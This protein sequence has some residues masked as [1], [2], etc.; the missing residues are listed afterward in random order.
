[1]QDYYNLQSIMQ[2][3]ALASRYR[4][5]GK[6]DNFMAS[7]GRYVWDGEDFLFANWYEVLEALSDFVDIREDEDTLTCRI[8]FSDESIRRYFERANA[9]AKAAGVP[10]KQSVLYQN[11]YEYYANTML[12]ACPCSCWFRL[13]A[14]P[15]HEYGYGL[16]VWIRE[17]QFPDWEALLYGL[18]DVMGYF[19][20]SVQT[21]D[22]EQPR[23]KLIELNEY[24][25][26]G[27]EAA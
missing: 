6:L 24:R 2:Q 15:H 27:K 10:L 4:E 14:Q 22:A 1:M 11:A 9:Q 16:S 21:W 3:L 8:Y 26:M 13:V 12:D 23:G 19:Y 7:T 17:E 18:L 25:S 5:I 20:R